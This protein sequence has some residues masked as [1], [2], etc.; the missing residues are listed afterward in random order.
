[1]CRS[2]IR[3]N[4]YSGSVQQV[5]PRVPAKNFWPSWQDFDAV[6]KT[7][8]QTCVIEIYICIIKVSSLAMVVLISSPHS[9]CLF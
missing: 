6:I 4:M 1:M 3:M 7:E 9:L 8:T 2:V 5:Y